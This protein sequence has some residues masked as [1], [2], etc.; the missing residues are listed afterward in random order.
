MT[1]RKDGQTMDE[2]NS[3]LL[4]RLRDELSDETMACATAMAIGLKL[5]PKQTEAIGK[6]LSELIIIAVSKTMDTMQEMA[7]ESIR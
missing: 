2:F 6:M 3:M 5:T 1:T 4:N 7:E